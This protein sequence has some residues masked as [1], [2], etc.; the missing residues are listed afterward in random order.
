MTHRHLTLSDRYC[1]Q[2]LLELEY[3]LL[4]SLILENILSICSLVSLE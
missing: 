3:S 4:K 1:I 2:N